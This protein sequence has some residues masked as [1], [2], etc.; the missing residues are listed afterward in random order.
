[1]TAFVPDIRATPVKCL[2]DECLRPVRLWRTHEIFGLTRPKDMRSTEPGL[3]AR[4]RAHFLLKF[5]PDFADNT[6]EGESE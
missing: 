5:G 3:S 6:N 4:G 1:V 2:A